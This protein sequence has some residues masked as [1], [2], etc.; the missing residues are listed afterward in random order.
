MK[1]PPQ[2]ENVRVTTRTVVFFVFVGIFVDSANKVLNSY[3]F[4]KIARWIVTYSSSICMMSKGRCCHAIY[5]L[6]IF[7]L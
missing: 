4:P 6:F 3:N 7:V 2:F 1:K 5:H